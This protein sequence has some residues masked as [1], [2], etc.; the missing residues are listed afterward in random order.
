ML[1]IGDDFRDAQMTGA[2]QFSSSRFLVLSAERGR[3]QDPTKRGLIA[4]RPG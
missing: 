4:G 2:G 1:Q 3:K